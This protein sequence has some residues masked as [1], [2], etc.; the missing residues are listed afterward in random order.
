MHRVCN[1]CYTA[2]EDHFVNLREKLLQGEALVDSKHSNRSLTSVIL[3]T[4]EESQSEACLPENVI[5]V[6]QDHFVDVFKETLVKHDFNGQVKDCLQACSQRFDRIEAGMRELG[7]TLNQTQRDLDNMR[8]EFYEPF[9]PQLKFLAPIEIIDQNSE[10]PKLGSF[11]VKQ[12]HQ[13]P[14]PL[15]NLLPP[16]CVVPSESEV[17]T[18][19]E[20]RNTGKLPPSGVLKVPKLELNSPVIACKSAWIK[21]PWERAT[22]VGIEN[23]KSAIY[24]CT[25]INLNFFRMGI[26]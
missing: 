4:T 6:L 18:V 13:P 19:E 15:T 11:K 12:T 1:A 17:L 7:S 26:K 8:N 2:A 16:T 3:D 23:V 5:R 20:F 14:R 10:S 22:V 9:N 21:G 25:L 24:M